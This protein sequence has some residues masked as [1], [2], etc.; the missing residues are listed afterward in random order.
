MDV[1]A[2]LEEMDRDY[3]YYLF[4]AEEFDMAE[5]WDCHTLVKC[6]IRA[7]HLLMDMGNEDTYEEDG[8]IIGE[9]IW[10]TKVMEKEN[11]ERIK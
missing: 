3:D 2:Y 1:N 9:I 10:A 11:A 8:F 5:F 4:W 6:Q 7:A